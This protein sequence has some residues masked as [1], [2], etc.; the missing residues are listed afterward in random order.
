MI[1]AGKLIHFPT[2]LTKEKS[3]KKEK[4]YCYFYQERL[5]RFITKR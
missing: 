4:D 5:K 3:T 1:I 2:L